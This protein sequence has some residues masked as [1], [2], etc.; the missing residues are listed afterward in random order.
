MA[1]DYSTAYDMI[2]AF[3]MEEATGATVSDELSNNDLTPVN[4]PTRTGTHMEGTYGKLFTLADSEYAIRSDSNLSSTFPFKS[5]G[6]NL[7]FTISCW[8]R[9]SAHSAGNGVLFS[10]YDTT[11][12]Q[13][14]F[15]CQ[16]VASDNKLKFYI[17]DGTSVELL[18]CDTTLNTGVWY[19]V[20]CCYDSSTKLAFFRVRKQTDDVPRDEDVRLTLTITPVACTSAFVIGAR[21]NGGVGVGTTNYLG[22]VLDE[23]IIFDRPLLRWEMDE[24]YKM[25]Y[26][27]TQPKNWYHT[28]YGMVAVYLM[29]AESWPNSAALADELG[30]WY[31]NQSRSENRLATG[32]AG[33]GPE[34]SPF[35]K[36]GLLG[37]GFAAGDSEYGNRSDGSLSSDFP[38]KT[39]TSNLSFSIC[40]WIR[41]ISHPAGNMGIFSKYNTG[42]GN[43]K[44]FL[45]YYNASNNTI[46]AHVGT[47][48][49]SEELG[50]GTGI[51]LN[52]YYHITY[53]YDNS[54]K[55]QWLRLRDTNGN[56]V[57]ADVTRTVTLTPSAT[58]ANLAIGCYYSSSARLGYY[59][60]TIDE[61]IVFNRA[62]TMA[63]S[64]AIATGSYPL[65]AG[66]DGGKQMGLLGIYP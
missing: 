7:S 43:Q 47:A 54:T 31:N 44:N 33:G 13:R 64:D 56:V 22:G 36:Q 46:R 60:G 41:Q 10:K 59:N 53:T 19:H 3:R 24:I 65:S 17:A 57:G 66:G 37:A 6:S 2:S 12:N 29:E 5:G 50:H 40:L 15:L 61:V 38:F 27:G 49:T 30:W 9:L 26:N 16:Y 63:E 14:G 23:L 28:D 62:I 45:I 34:P 1:N 48:G 4:N 20:I 55:T 42:T 39:G 52:T 58:A 18:T 51:S 21:Q 8:F 32:G 35:R 25:S 11:G